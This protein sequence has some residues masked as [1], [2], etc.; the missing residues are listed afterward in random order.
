M[1]WSIVKECL[2]TISQSNVNKHALKDRKNICI[3]LYIMHTIE[4]SIFENFD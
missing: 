3:M 2:C 1:S 4:F